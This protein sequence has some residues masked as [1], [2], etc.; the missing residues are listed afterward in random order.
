MTSQP[1]PGL[2]EAEREH[3]S[4]KFDQDVQRLQK[5]AKLLDS[6]FPIVG[7]FRIGVDGIIGLIPG[8]GD[9]VG[10]SLSTY[11]IVKAAQMGASTFNLIRMMANVLFEAIVGVI[12]FLGDLFDVAFR[13]NE[14]NVR[15]LQKQLDKE[16]S[17][18]NSKTR[19]SA[20]VI[21][22]LGVFVAVLISLVLLAFKL[23]LML[24][25]GFV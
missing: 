10:A 14:R 17:R 13:A 18:V 24:F 12:P 9:V 23:L 21:L 16:P 7:N 20:A 25:S 4:I 11:M 19:L 2:P 1:P 5:M 3:Q 6:A 15:L 22:L 8:I